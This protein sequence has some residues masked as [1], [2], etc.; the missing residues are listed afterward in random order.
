MYDYQLE[1]HEEAAGVWLS[2]PV[3]PEMNATG[4]TLEEALATAADALETALSFYVDDRKPIPLPGMRLRGNYVTFRLPAL[5]AAKVSL[6]NAMCA[7]GVTKIELARRMNV[8]RPQVDRLLD[9]LHDSR[10]DGL[11][12]ALQALGR[13]LSVTVEAA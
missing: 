1:V 12:R 4:E 7:E 6:W 3:V 8:A 5:A 13:R 9:F 2:C 10:M 11:E